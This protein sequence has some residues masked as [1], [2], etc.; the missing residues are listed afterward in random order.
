VDC[1]DFVL[2]NFSYQFFPQATEPSR[3]Y[4]VEDST[5]LGETI[6]TLAT[7]FFTVYKRK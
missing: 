2:A 6:R 3:W 7:E 1:S 5:A 4:L